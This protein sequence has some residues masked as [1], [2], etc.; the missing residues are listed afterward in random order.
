MFKNKKKFRS[1]LAV[2]WQLASDNS[3][4]LNC[5]QTDR[6]ERTCWLHT[7]ILG[8]CRQACTPKLWATALCPR[9]ALD[10]VPFLVLRLVR[11]GSFFQLPDWAEDQRVGCFQ[12][13][14]VALPP[15]SA[16]LLRQAAPGLGITM[17]MIIIRLLPP[18]NQLDCIFLFS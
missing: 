18:H 6:T 1:N 15:C 8:A 2:Y 9:R 7:L 10:I 17:I 12:T 4:S 3:S 13:T 11:C 5:P 14:E 16:A